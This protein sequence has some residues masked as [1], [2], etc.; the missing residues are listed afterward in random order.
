M[1]FRFLSF[2]HVKKV[3]NV[4]ALSVRNIF[5]NVIHNILPDVLI[6]ALPYIF[7]ETSTYLSHF[8]RV[9]TRYHHAFKKTIFEG[10]TTYSD[11]NGRN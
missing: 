7:N 1:A 8:Q 5:E 3:W 2:I 6:Y 11:I 10:I 9:T 4:E